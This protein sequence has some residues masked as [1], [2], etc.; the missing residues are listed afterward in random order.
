MPMAARVKI[1]AVG[2]SNSLVIFLFILALCLMKNVEVW[3]IHIPKGNVNI[4]MGIMLIISFIS[5][6]LV[7]VA[8]FHGLCFSAELLPS[9][10]IIAALSRNLN[11]INLSSD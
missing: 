9:L 8:S 6:T 11:D 10:T 3:A 2:I 1:E 5:S 7:T 4:Q